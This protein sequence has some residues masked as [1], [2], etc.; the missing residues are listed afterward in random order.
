MVR[1]KIDPEKL[2]MP[3]FEEFDIFDELGQEFII[4]KKWQFLKVE[5]KL[6]RHPQWS[7]DKIPH[8]EK[9]EDVVEFISGLKDSTKERFYAIFLDNRNGILGIHEISVGSTSS[10]Y[11][12]P[13]DCFQ[14]AILSN[15][16]R[17]IFV[18]NHPSGYL[19]FSSEDI[20]IA[21]RLKAVGNL[22]GIEVLDFIL[23]TAEGFL[24]AKNK[25]LV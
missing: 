7:Y 3:F 5:T 13:K 10:S 14:S 17:I 12:H 18:H 8:I 11:V 4:P 21:Q 23:I 2:Y 24:S 9:P 22:L 6:V 19:E 1:Y 20:A 15:A 25:N 16:T